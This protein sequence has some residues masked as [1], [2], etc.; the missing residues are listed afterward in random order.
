MKATNAYTAKRGLFDF[1]TGVAPFVGADA[2]QLLYA[3]NDRLLERTCVYG[4]GAR[5][6]Q[7]AET[8]E[9]GIRFEMV[10]TGLYVRALTPGLDVRAAELVV[11]G[12]ADAV[13]TTLTDHPDLGGGLT[14]EQIVGGSAEWWPTDDAVEVILALSCQIESH[15]T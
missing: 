1:L 10:T 15:L 2:V 4:G 3:R 14:F 13:A 11:E 5:F 8:A 6:V 7:S 9:G 12:I